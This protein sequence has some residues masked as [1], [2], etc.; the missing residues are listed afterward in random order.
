MLKAEV[1]AFAI[2]PSDV[3]AAFSAYNSAFYTVSGTNGYFKN[4]QS[5]GIEYFL[6]SGGGN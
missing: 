6:E 2:S 4:D 1:P 3:N 5:G